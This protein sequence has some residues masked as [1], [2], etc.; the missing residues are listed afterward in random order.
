MCESPANPDSPKPEL[1]GKEEFVRVSYKE[2]ISLI[3]KELKKTREKKGNNAICAGSYGWKSTG[4]VQNARVL[5]HRFMNVTGGFVGVTGDYSTGA[6]QVIMPYVVGSIEVYE[7]QT[8]WENILENTKLVVLWGCDPIAVGRLSWTINEQSTI[9][10]FEKL[11]T[12]KIKVICIDPVRTQSAKFL[13]A[14]WIAPKPN[15]DVALMMGMASHLIAVKKV[16]YD[17]L[18]NYTVGFDKFKAYLDGSEDGVK[19]D[20]KWASKI[21]GIDEKTIKKLAETM[22]DST[23]MIMSGWSMQRV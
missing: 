10:Y 6:S 8:S 2:A 22:F 15:T 12:K 14:Q 18:E 7:Q 19:K 13:N 9:R 16:D 5:L 11:K 17:F 20:A 23:T 1:R 3:A 21:C 4:N